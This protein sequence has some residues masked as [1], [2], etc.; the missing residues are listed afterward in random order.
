MRPALPAALAGV[1]LLAGCGGA[2]GGGKATVWVTRDEGRHVVLTGTARAM[3]GELTIVDLDGG[4]EASTTD[5]GTGRVALSVYPWEI[6][7]AQPRARAH[8]P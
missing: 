6:T 3:N 7:I 1:A 4:G 2:G 5:P 8:V